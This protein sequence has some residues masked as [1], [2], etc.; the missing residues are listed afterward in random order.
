MSLFIY[1]TASEVLILL[2][3]VDD[4]LVTRSNQKL[5]SHFIF[6]LHDKFALRDLGPLSYLLGIQAHRQGLILHFNQQKYIT[7]L[8]SRTHMENSKLAPTPGSLGRTLSQSDGVPLPN[9][10]KYRRTVGVL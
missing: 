7:D 2:V 5:I 9:P 10:S 8:I 4:I 3:Y 1:D 6:Y